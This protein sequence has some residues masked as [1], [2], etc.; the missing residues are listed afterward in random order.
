[1]NLIPI[2]MTN[3]VLCISPV[4]QD[5]YDSFTVNYEVV[6]FD[7]AFRILDQGPYSTD[8]DCLSSTLE[9]SEMSTV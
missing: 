9:W 7:I 4:T 1:M 3:Y 6:L 5:A 2:A 8:L